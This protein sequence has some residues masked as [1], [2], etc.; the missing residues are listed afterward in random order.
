MWGKR[1]LSVLLVGVIAFSSFGGNGITAYASDMEI[2]NESDDLYLIEDEEI[3]LDDTELPEAEEADQ[4]SSEEYETTEEPAEDVGFTTIDNGLCGDTLFWTL[5]EDDDYTLYIYGTGEMYS[6]GEVPW[7]KY[8]KQI[9]HVDIADGVTYIG[10]SAFADFTNLT[11]IT[12]PD[13]VEIIGF[14]AFQNCKNLRTV[15]FSNSLKSIAMYAFYG[16]SSLT[17]VILPDTVYNISQNAFEGCSSMETLKL[18]GSLSDL[19]DRSFKGCTSLTSVTLPSKMERLNSGVFQNCT[20][21]KSIIVPRYF[22]RIGGNSFDGCDNLK[23]V[24]F[25]GTKKEFQEIEI[26]SGNDKFKKAKIHYEYVEELKPYSGQFTFGLSNDDGKVETTKYDYT[27]DFYDFFKSSYEHQESLIRMSLRVAMAAMDPDEYTGTSQRAYYIKK[28]MNQLGFNYTS[29]DI[30]YENPNG[31]TIGTAIGSKQVRNGDDEFTLVMVAVRGGGYLSEWAGNVNVGDRGVHLT[32]NHNGFDIASDTVIRRISSYLSRNKLTDRSKVK[33]WICGYSRAAAVSN[34]TA[35]KLDDG[36]ISGITS[37]NVYAFCYECP[38]NTQNGKYRDS[39]YNNIVNIVNLVDL[40]PLVAPFNDDGW[41]Y[42]RFGKTYYIDDGNSRRKAFSRNYDKMKGTY[43]NILGDYYSKERLNKQVVKAGTNRKIRSYDETLMECLTRILPRP[44]DY[45]FYQNTIYSIIMQKMKQGHLNLAKT[46]VV[47]LGVI[48]S[49]SVHKAYNYFKKASPY[50]AI[51]H[52]PELTLAWV[53]TLSIDDYLN[54]KEISG[55]RKSIFNCPVDIIVKDAEGNIVGQIIDNEAIDIEDGVL[56]DV[57]EDGQKVVILP[58]TGDFRIEARAYDEGEVSISTFVYSG[59]A[60]I[61]DKVESYQKIK[62]N[63]DD[64]I[65]VDAAEES[66]SVTGNDG[67]IL[68]PDVTQNRDEITDLLVEVSSK[69]PGT[70]EGGGIYYV[71]E[72][73]QVTAT[74]AEGKTFVGWYEDG[75]LVSDQATYRFLVDKNILINALFTEKPI[76]EFSLQF[77]D[78]AIDVYDGLTYNASNNQYETVFTGVSIEPSVLVVGAKG[79]LNEGTDYTISYKNNVN[80]GTKGKASTVIV[81]GKGNYSGKK[82]LD[83]YILPADLGI[84][85]E[86][87][88]LS[89]PEEITVQSGKKISPVIT[90]GDYTLKAKDMDLSVKD[91]VKADTTVD[92]S[93]KGNFKGTI[94]GINVKL[95]EAE[96]AKKY[97][98]KAQVKAASHVYTGE[99]V[100]LSCST[101]E[102]AGEITV[103]AGDSKTP[104]IE[105][106]DY[107]VSYKSNVDAGTATVIITGCGEYMGKV[108]KT[109]KVL[110]DKTSEIKV[111]LSGPSEEIYY[112]PDGVEPKVTVTIAKA[113]GESDELVEGRDYTVSYSNNKA[114]GTGKYTVSFIGNYNGHAAIK[115]NT[116]TISAAPFENAKVEAA[117]LV[118]TKPG[119]Y[120]SDVYVSMN[121]VALNAKNY[122]VEY[123]DDETKLSKKSKIEFDDATRQKEIIVKV[124]G[125]GNYKAE[126]VIAT[127]FVRKADDSIVNLSEAK[128]VALEK[129][130]KGKDVAVGKQEYTG[131]EIK[132]EIRVLVKDGKSFIEVPEGSYTVRYVNNTKRGKATIIVS[133]NGEKAVGSV[134]TTFKIGTKNLGLFKWLFG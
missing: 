117:D 76:D 21:L 120:L 106:T 61:P 31:D 58:E 72:F 65:I 62:V 128:I 43:K 121:G 80:V 45:M 56:T 68:E 57:D 75:V 33:I 101:P 108:T 51:S 119:S 127:Y 7:A 32:E 27:I 67:D 42:H 16:C 11:E 34:L 4:I 78:T 112:S 87:G 9:K 49:P 69:G 92:I 125:R 130:S 35:A 123:Y 74:P 59:E 60:L 70:A 8:K 14:Y 94:E 10:S 95:L 26:A 83:F 41:M 131:K 25:V 91:P 82:T 84:A 17:S 134:K 52:Y 86:K 66:L 5:E 46:L 104:L 113:E 29:N 38:Q 102:E 81:T 15:K 100:V 48:D 122:S 111:A 44:Y 18:S 114:V 50:I 22:C 88:L 28:L 64:S 110:P 103:T 55:K 12:L 71:G 129:N 40:V 90:Y 2:V 20:Q 93:G 24:Y 118:Y 85:N 63:K 13:S 96:S 39:H 73:C 126:E 37:E 1:A 107:F 36:I 98:I 97:T 133:G 47:I 19:C 132:P 77:F 105:G 53:D 3:V 115:S 30:N 109:F 124:S 89:V 99:P 116:F 54:E 6:K 79:I 23:D